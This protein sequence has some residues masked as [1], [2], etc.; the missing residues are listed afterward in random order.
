MKKDIIKRIQKL[1][2]LADTSKNS[3]IEEAAAAA[4]K[5]QALMEKHRIKKAMLDVS[6]KEILTRKTLID[7]GRPENWK[8]YL[9]NA[10]SK[11]NGCYIIK[12]ADYEKDNVMCVAGEVKDIETVQE[13]KEDLEELLLD[14]K[15]L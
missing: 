4:T 3:N 1:L 8:V 6:D 2:K 9:C 11:H 10:I 5:A 15:S 13:L 7:K 14:L 12:S